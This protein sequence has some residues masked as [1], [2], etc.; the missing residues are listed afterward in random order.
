MVPL[1]GVFPQPIGQPSSLGPVSSVQLDLGENPS[2]VVP[3]PFWSDHARAELELSRARPRD[4]DALEHQQTQIPAVEDLQER[5]EDEQAD[6]PLAGQGD[7]SHP[8]GPQDRQGGNAN[9]RERSTSPGVRA[10]LVEL[11]GLMEAVIQ[12]QQEHGTRLERLEAAELHSACSAASG[13][14]GRTG[15]SRVQRVPVGESSRIIGSRVQGDC[16]PVSQEEI[17]GSAATIP[18]LR[19][20]SSACEYFYIGDRERGREE[21]RGAMP[22]KMNSGLGTSRTPPP[23]EGS[24]VHGPAYHC[25]AVSG[26]RESVDARGYGWGFE[27]QTQQNCQ[28]SEHPYQGRISG[29][30]GS[31]MSCQTGQGFAAGGGCL[32]PSAPAEPACGTASACVSSQPFA[33]VQSTMSMQ[34]SRHVPV[35]A[36]A[37]APEPTPSPSVFSARN[38]FSNPLPPGDMGVWQVGGAGNGGGM[39][40]PWIS[41][42]A[43]GDGFQG[44]G[45]GP[46][47]GGG[48]DHSGQSGGPPGPGGAAG[49]GGLGGPG[50]QGISERFA[51]LQQAWAGPPGRDEFA[52]GDRALWELPALG[53]P[54]PNTSPIQLGDWMSLIFPMMCDLAPSSCIW[55]NQVVQESEQWYYRWQA[56]NPMQRGQLRVTLS[57]E[58]ASHRFVRLESRATGMLLKS[59]PDVAKQEIIASRSMTTVGILFRLMVLFQPGGLRERTLL[60][61]FLHQ[62]GTASSPE[63]GVGLLRRWHR[64]IARAQAMNAALPDAALLMSG[65]D[66]LAALVLQTHPNVAF[67]L[68]LVRTE[69]R[70]DHV[71]VFDAVVAYARA[72]QSELEQAAIAPSS[73]ETSPKKPRLARAEKGGG[74]D[75]KG[76][77]KGGDSLK[78]GGGEPKGSNGKGRAEGQSSSSGNKGGKGGKSQEQAQQAENPKAAPTPNPQPTPPKKPLCTYHASDNGCKLGRTCPHAHDQT[79]VPGAPLKCWT[80]GSIHHK[81]QDCPYAKKSDTVQDPSSHNILVLKLGL[82]LQHQ[83]PLPIRKPLQLPLLKPCLRLPLLQIRFWL[84]PQRDF[85]ISGWHRL[86]WFQPQLPACVC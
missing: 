68:N 25:E 23:L 64:W 33:P 6:T 43:G 47:R 61:S 45:G 19:Q 2:A 77:P 62:P 75:A 42:G 55:W 52:P 27:N 35:S 84:K 74:A 78:G 20:G 32:S 21:I 5:P 80:C 16:Y 70:L 65:I 54:D 36:F 66:Q 24:M 15:T 57:A 58:L 85:R 26:A 56:L 1:S 67:R 86:D 71:P 82:Q 40:R 48:Q 29:G 50:G 76:A 4:L 14:A 59:I 8:E 37:R 79:V 72:L 63:H 34:S 49:L 17:G 10:I 51:N 3:H 83:K 28:G 53:D 11:K 31:G 22:G 7:G 73:A 60:L 12:T 18:A 46:E 30:P 9:N 81:K 38:P 13:S 44:N 39:N 69:H 41:E